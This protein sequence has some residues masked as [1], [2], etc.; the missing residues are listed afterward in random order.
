[1][2]SGYAIQPNMNPYSGSKR[3]CVVIT[4]PSPGDFSYLPL[5]GRA[6]LHD[7]SE[8]EDTLGYVLIL[9][10]RKELESDLVIGNG[11][12]RAPVAMTLEN[13]LTHFAGG[14]EP[15][16]YAKDVEVQTFEEALA[17]YGLERLS[18]PPAR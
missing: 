16:F 14:M 15:E 18:A 9:W 17:E 6:T 3:K 10:A 4:E 8:I 2:A 13:G 1:M 12:W 5:R 11:E 7:G